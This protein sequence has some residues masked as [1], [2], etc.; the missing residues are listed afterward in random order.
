MSLWL[1]VAVVTTLVV[2]GFALHRLADGMRAHPTDTTPPGP[3][4]QRPP[5]DRDVAP[6]PSLAL[7]EQLVADAAMSRNLTTQRLWP[8]VAQ[9]ARARRI[10]DPRVHP[11]GADTL[12]WLR[13]ALDALEGPATPPSSRPER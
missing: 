10:R 4:I 2:A 1:I 12:A 8:L 6:P 13:S 11:P 3:V 9:L 7:T 5:A